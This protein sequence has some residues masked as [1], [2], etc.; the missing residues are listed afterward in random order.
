MRHIASTLRVSFPNKR[1]R[2]TRL[3]AGLSDRCL[4][5]LNQR[6]DIQ[7]AG[8]QGF[9]ALNLSLAVRFTGGYFTTYPLSSSVIYRFGRFNRR[10]QFSRCLA[11][12][13]NR[14]DMICESSYRHLAWHIF[15]DRYTFHRR[16]VQ[17]RHRQGQSTSNS[18]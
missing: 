2:C 6:A 17:Q 9:R 16:V 1:K 18:R 12:S 14:F 8:L 15:P 10:C 4:L 13:N 11:L 7:P 3:G 5:F